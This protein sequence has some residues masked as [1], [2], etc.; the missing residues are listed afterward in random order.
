MM[1]NLPFVYQAQCVVVAALCTMALWWFCSLLD[2][3]K[4]MTL[5]YTIL[6]WVHSMVRLFYGPAVRPAPNGDQK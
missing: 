6:Y 4:W 2:T 1:G 5:S 3:P